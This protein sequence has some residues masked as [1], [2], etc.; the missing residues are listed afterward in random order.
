MFLLLA[1]VK[2]NKK[3][4]CKKDQLRL[5]VFSLQINLVEGRVR[6][7]KLINKDLVS[8][9][10]KVMAINKKQSNKYQYRKFIN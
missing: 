4:L 7:K 8:M 9:K 3:Q 5:W 10:L 6:C 1:H 2:K